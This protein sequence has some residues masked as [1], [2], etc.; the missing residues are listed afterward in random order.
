MPIAPAL[1]AR[2][3]SAAKRSDQPGSLMPSALNVMKFATRSL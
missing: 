1:N 2:S 3:I